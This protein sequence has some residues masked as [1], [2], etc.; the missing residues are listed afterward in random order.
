MFFGMGRK[1]PVPRRFTYVPRYYDPDKH[2]SREE[3]MSFER[4]SGYGGKRR[5]GRASLLFYL[6]VASILISLMWLLSPKRVHHQTLNDIHLTA[7]DE[8]II[9]DQQFSE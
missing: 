1:G 3:R 9:I 4:T 8:V 6:L 5:S 2:L 7:D